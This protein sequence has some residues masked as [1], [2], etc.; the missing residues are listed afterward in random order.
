MCEGGLF[1]VVERWFHSLPV[2]QATI[3]FGYCPITA[4]LPV[5]PHCQNARR[6]RC[7]KDLNSFSLVE[8]EETTGTPLYY[9]DEDYPAGPDIQQ[10]LPEWSSWRGSDTLE[11]DVY[12]CRYTLLVMHVRG[13]RLLLWLRVQRAGSMNVMPNTHRRRDSTVELRRVGVGGVYWIRN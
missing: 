11:T 1:V 8:L 7:Q 2:Y 5:Q 9:V 3:P 4:F 13:R 12:V 6:N 10:P